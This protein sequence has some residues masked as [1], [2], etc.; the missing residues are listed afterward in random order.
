[1]GTAS[2]NAFPAQAAFTIIL[3]AKMIEQ[4]LKFQ[5]ILEKYPIYIPLA[6]VAKFLNMKPEGFADV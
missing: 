6:V 3:P 4:R 5:E 2:I 1:M